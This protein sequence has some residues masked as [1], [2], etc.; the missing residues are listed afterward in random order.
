MNVA[1]LKTSNTPNHL[2]AGNKTSVQKT[3]IENELTPHDPPIPQYQIIGS[4]ALY[5][6]LSSA[7]VTVY[8]PFGAKSVDVNW[9]DPRSATTSN[10]RMSSEQITSSSVYHSDSIGITLAE[11]EQLPSAIRRNELDWETVSNSTIVEAKTFILRFWHLVTSRLA[12]WDSPHVASDGNGEVTFEWWQGSHT[13]TFF[14][15]P[16]GIVSCLTSWGYHIWDEMDEIVEPSDDDLIKIWSWLRD[17][18]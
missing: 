3:P 11:I 5:D 7:T 13:L 12:D 10:T 1:T 2:Y 18:K 8:V 14:V 15:Q 16:D 9:A 6:L 17:R 4:R